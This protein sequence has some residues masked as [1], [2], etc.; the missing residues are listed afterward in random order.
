MIFMNH[1]ISSLNVSIDKSL[2]KLYIYDVS[3][4]QYGEVITLVCMLLSFMGIHY[5]T[6]CTSKKNSILF[7]P[8][9]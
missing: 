9:L 2:W 6:M 8:W 7:W 3:S 5:W 1:N 4:Y